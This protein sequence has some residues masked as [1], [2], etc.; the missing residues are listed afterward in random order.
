MRIQPLIRP[1]IGFYAICLLV[2]FA[3]SYFT[4]MSVGSW[5]LTLDKS[6]FTPPG[7]VFGIAWTLLYI[8]MSMAAARIYHRIGTL[9]NR[10][11]RWWLIQLVAGWSGRSCS[12]A[13][14]P[15]PRGW[16]C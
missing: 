12:S 4:Q 8:C 1:F 3:G 9:N 11:M 14:A 2:Q 7:Y 6:P 15:S 13:T 16:A 10:P 5:Y